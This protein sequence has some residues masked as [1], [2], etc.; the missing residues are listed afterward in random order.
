MEGDARGQP[1]ARFE[2]FVLDL[3]TGEL[4]KAGEKSLRLPEQ[5]FQILTMLLEHPGEVVSREKIRKRLW[6]N[7]TVVEFEHSINAAMNKLRQALGDS[8]GDPR[9]IETLAGRGYRWMRSVEWVDTSTPSAG[10]TLTMSGSVAVNLIG[11]K[12]SHYRVLAVIGGGGMGIVYKAE[13]IKL[14]RRVALKFLPE[15][16]AN[17]QR[18]LERFEREARAA[19]ALNHPNIC[20]IHEI[21]EHEGQPFIVMELLDGQ[22]LRDVISSTAG[23]PPLESEKLLDLAIQITDGLEAAH[24]KGIIHRDIKPSNVFITHRGEAKIMDF[25]VAKLLAF[26]EPVEAKIPVGAPG[27]IQES[28]PPGIRSAYLTRTG[29]ALGTEGYMSPEQVRGE[30]LDSRTDLFSFGLVL[31]EMAC[32]ARAFGGDTAPVIHEAILNQSP[33][34]AREINP[35]LPTELGH[36]IDKALEK[37]RELRYRRAS[38]IRDDLKSIVA[39]APRA[40]SVSTVK[41]LLHRPR[42]IFAAGLLISLSSALVS[43]WWLKGRETLNASLMIQRQLTTNSSEIPV[44]SGA[45]SPDGKYLA[46]ADSRGIH[47]KLIKTGETRTLPEPESL[48]RI[49]VNWGIINGWIPD[50]TGLIANAIIAGR[51]PSIWMVS[52]HGGTPR[53]LRD[54]AFAGA[55]SRDGAWVAF[56]ANPG[57]VGYREMWIMRPDGTDARLIFEGDANNGFSG[58][59][60]SPDGRRISFEWGQRIGDKEDWKMVTRDVKG[61]PPETAIPAGI[62][63]WS[64]SP[65]WRM[66]Y[67]TGEPQS[68]PGSCNFWTVDLN[69]RTGKPLAPARRLTNWAGFCIDNPSVTADGRLLAFRRWSPQGEVYVASLEN[70]QLNTSLPRRLTLSEGSNY[71]TSWTADNKAIIFESYQDGRWQV[72][73]QALNSDTADPIETGMDED[74]LDARL[75]ADGAGIFYVAVPKGDDPSPMRR[76]LSISL[77]GGTPKLVMSANTYG[78]PR[79]SRSPATLCAIAEQTPDR[80]ELIFTAFD[81]ESRGR[82]LLRFKTDPKSYFNYV[83]DLSP[84][85][86]RIA[87]LKGSENRITILSL[88]GKRPHE[89]TVSHWNE[90]QSVDWESGGEEFFVSSHTR[91][92]VVLLRVDQHG[93]SRVIWEHKGS[94]APWNWPPSKW[95]VGP[96]APWAVPSPDGHHIAIYEWNMNANMWMLEN[97]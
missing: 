84:D 12:V 72:F 21:A 7:D 87:V 59:E 44:S 76:L 30:S 14:G 25:G 62:V 92:G 34:P 81:S 6:P 47:I 80:E 97:F 56:I 45:I 53:K 46:Y 79:C 55:I 15:E 90:L 43:I 77:S 11:K 35:R 82:E 94:I 83:W 40:A 17:D 42:L 27:R 38:E 16:L 26:D 23:R 18:A 52:P 24:Q 58:A 32:G 4:R 71:P 60:W 78:G 91:D 65:D 74:V 89:I 51:E 22:T 19:S 86:T 93:N 68:G 67:S 5:S 39:G 75:S 50:G 95:L 70:K 37:D 28:D 69:R 96:S 29:I 20:T 31:Y 88:R 54:N 8:A 85:G 63:D 2:D 36:I 1:F 61:G 66:I 49:K 57:P 73:K 48:Q 3:G 9:Y 10:A 13:D 41:T 33:V 64:W